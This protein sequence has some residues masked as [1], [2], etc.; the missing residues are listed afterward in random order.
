ME[1]HD[2]LTIPNLGRM[3]VM[4]SVKNAEDMV[5]EDEYAKK[6]TALDF[7]YNRNIDSHIDPFF[8]GHTLSQIP[9]TF[10]RVLPKFARARMMLYKAP[11]RRFINGEM[12]D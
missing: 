3:A 4:D 7:Y 5:L 12:A 6:Q 8:P 9:V 10:L 2:K 11:P 1:F